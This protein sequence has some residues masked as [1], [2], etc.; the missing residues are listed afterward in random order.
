[1]AKRMLL[2]LAAV[3]PFVVPVAAEEAPHHTMVAADAIEWGP[4][5]AALPAGVKL[6]VLSGNPGAEGPFTIRVWAADGTRVPPH[7]HPTTEHLT[8]ISGIFHVGTGETFDQAAANPLR[9][10]DFAAM[11]AEMRH[12]A[13]TEGDTVVQVHG[14]GPFVLNYVNPADDP[15]QAA[16]PGG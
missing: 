6:A 7:W 13:W 5:P 14:M 16:K 15:R 2:V 12:F 9:P 10:G 8:V 3:L 11:P 1:M 4:G